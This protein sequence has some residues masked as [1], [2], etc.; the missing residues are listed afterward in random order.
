MV[1]RERILVGLRLPRLEGL[2]EPPQKEKGQGKAGQ[3]TIAVN[4]RH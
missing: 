4:V 1:L 3:R 2:P